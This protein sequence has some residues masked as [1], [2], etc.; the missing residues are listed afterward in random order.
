MSVSSDFI[1]WVFGRVLGWERHDRI[2]A[3]EKSH[4]CTYGERKTSRES[5][6]KKISRRLLLEGLNR[7]TQEGYEKYKGDAI[8]RIGFKD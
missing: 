7:G 3:L 2:F 1:L 6:S 4:Y 5:G 8:K